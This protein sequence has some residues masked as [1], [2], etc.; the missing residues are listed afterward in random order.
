M[1]SKS[2]DNLKCYDYEN[3]IVKIEKPNG[4]GKTTVA[5]YSYDA[6]GRRIRKI[7]S[8]ASSTT[9]YYNN[10]NWQVLSKYGLKK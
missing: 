2:F 9:V 4:G 5:E 1:Y 3:R 7:D 8:I 10:S 6:L